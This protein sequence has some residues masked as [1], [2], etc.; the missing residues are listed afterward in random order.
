RMTAVISDMSQPLG[1]AV[2]NALE[3]TEAI[4]T[5][6]GGGPPDF[7]GHVLTVAAEMLAMRR[8]TVAVPEEEWDRAEAAL[9]DGTAWEKFRQFVAA[10]G[11]DIAAVDDPSRLPQAK[12]VVPFLAEVPGYVQA[13]DA[14]AI[15]MAVVDLGGGRERKGEPID[16][17][18]GIVMRARLG[19]RVEVGQPLCDIHANDE[20]RLERAQER[21][22]RAFTV[23]EEPVALPPLIY[24]VLR[25][26]P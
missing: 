15:G 2:G 21:L 11:G 24:Q 22:R 23:G 17:A 8:G 6:R 7:R 1:R 12:L 10:Q 4:K 26:R 25:A 16:P 3:V 9:R 20:T 14:A 13:I 18:V 19:D 5:L